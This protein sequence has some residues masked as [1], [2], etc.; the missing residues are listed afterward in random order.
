M[1]SVFTKRIIFLKSVCD[2]NVK[3]S[4]FGGIRRVDLMRQN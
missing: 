2:V 4:H 3:K 1:V